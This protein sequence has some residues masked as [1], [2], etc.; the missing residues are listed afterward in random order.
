MYLLDTNHCSFIS[1]RK[2][3]QVIQKLKSL[4]VD[5]EIAI[6]SIIYG[7]LVMM[8]EKSQRKEENRALLDSFVQRLRIHSMDKETSE[9][10]GRFY[11]EIFDKFAPKDKT[12]RRKFD[13]KEAGVQTHDLWIACTAIQHDLVLVSEDRDFQVM[14]Q[15]KTLKLE[16]WKTR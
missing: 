14:N 6:N 13:I 16:C 11:A 12:E 15:V 7:E 10:Y 2:D 4:P 8:I 3:A 1:A 9:I 5:T